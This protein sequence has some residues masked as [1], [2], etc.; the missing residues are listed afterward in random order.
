MQT[1]QAHTNTPRPTRPNRPATATL[2]AIAAAATLHIAAG[3]T[4]TTAAATNIYPQSPTTPAQA[5][6]PETFVTVAADPALLMCRVGSVA[7]PVA[8]LRIGQTLRVVGTTQDWVRVEY[9]A[10]VNAY[11]PADG[12]Q[13]IRTTTGQ[14]KLRLTRPDKLMALMANAEPQRSYWPIFERGTG[15]APGDEF[16]I[17]ETVRAAGQADAEPLGYIIPAPTGATGWIRDT[18]LRPA[19]QQEIATL[20]QPTTTPTQQPTTP[21]PTPTPTPTTE[22]TQP[23]TPTTT[24]TLPPSFGFF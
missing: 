22:T 16:T 3:T 21:T 8:T 1:Q 19:T 6:Q 15:P 14:N 17:I 12:A 11:V 24:T 4:T 13:I 5:N 20:R 7:Y 9:P 10:G 23:T 2:L 18:R